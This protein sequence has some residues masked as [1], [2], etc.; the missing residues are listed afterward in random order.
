MT[1]A[2]DMANIASGA[3]NAPI[4]DGSITTAKL[5]ANAVT[6]AKLHTAL[7]L[8]SKTLTMPS[9]IS[10][11]KR[12][13]NGRNTASTGLAFSTTPQTL[14]S[15]PNVVVNSGEKV[16][17]AYHVT[18]RATGNCQVHAAV[19]PHYSG[20]ATGY[21]GDSQWGLGIHDPQSHHQW[22]V[23]SSFVSLT[24]YNPGGGGPFNSTGTFNFDIKMRSVNTSG[25][26]GNEG[27]NV[28]NQYTPMMGT[29]LVG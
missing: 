14:F 9:G 6:D 8:S 28:N 15:I 29:I 12:V 19:I 24:D 5:A 11:F 25:Q 20:S 17:L 10:A 7:D 4:A 1:R 13:Y 16:W 26:F 2:R 3:F 27:A 21:V 18:I 23:L 22:N